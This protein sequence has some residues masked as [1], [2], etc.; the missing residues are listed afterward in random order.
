MIVKISPDTDTA[1]NLRFGDAETTEDTGF[2]RAELNEKGD[3]TFE[4]TNNSKSEAE[5]TIE[6]T[7]STKDK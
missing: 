5:F 2:L 4:V 7:I 6:V 1:V 3:Y